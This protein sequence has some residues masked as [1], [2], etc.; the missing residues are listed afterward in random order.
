MKICERASAEAAA[1]CDLDE[2]PTASEQRSESGR[3]VKQLWDPQQFFN[4]FTLVLASIRST[5]SAVEATD[6]AEDLPTKVDRHLAALVRAATDF[7]YRRHELEA[8]MWMV[9][10][11]GADLNFVKLIDQPTLD[12]LLTAIQRQKD[13]T[14]LEKVQLTFE[15]GRMGAAGRYPSNDG[16]S[17]LTAEQW[18]RITELIGTDP[19][20]LRVII[21][22]LLSGH[23]HR[24]RLQQKSR[25]LIDEDRLCQKRISRGARELARE[26]TGQIDQQMLTAQADRAVRDALL[27]RAEFAD[28]VAAAPLPECAHKSWPRYELQ[29]GLFLLWQ[30]I[31]RRAE[32]GKQ[33][34]VTC[35]EAVGIAPHNVRDSLK[36]FRS[37]HAPRLK[38]RGL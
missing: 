7:E 30:A 35:S 15:C 11:I 28:A 37:E 12:S 5:P 36:K 1:L 33:F 24:L 14:S 9:Y 21:D 6:G 31:G 17:R 34:V 18:R 25:A 26:L 8:L 22:W 20:H 19:L 23:S 10:S 13:L 3:G 4:A 2:Q 29:K 16:R 32:D 38:P 27:A